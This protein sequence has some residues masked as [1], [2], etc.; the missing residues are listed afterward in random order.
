LKKKQVNNPIDNNGTVLRTVDD[1]EILRHFI[2]EGGEA[3][4]S[5]EYDFAR[6]IARGV[7]EW[8]YQKREPQNIEY[9][10]QFKA[11]KKQLA[12][13]LTVLLANMME[14]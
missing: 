8:L 11:Q 2:V 4:G 10:K 5:V 12:E 9:T 14:S 1:Y 3:P 7:A 13:N 6:L